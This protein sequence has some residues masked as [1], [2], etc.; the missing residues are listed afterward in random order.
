M[1]DLGIYK[2][3]FDNRDEAIKISR[4]YTII[5][6]STIYAMLRIPQISRD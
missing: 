2:N 5:K 4:L 6:N 3:L 1:T